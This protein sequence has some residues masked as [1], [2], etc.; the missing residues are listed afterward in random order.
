M[1]T[2]F[3][4]IEPPNVPSSPRDD[5]RPVVTILMFDSVIDDPFPVAKTAFAPAAPVVIEQFDRVTFPADS[6]STPA[7]SP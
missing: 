1:L 4:V 6:A 5:P 2:F 7:L 3:A